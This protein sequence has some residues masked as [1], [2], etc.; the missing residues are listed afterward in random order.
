MEPPVPTGT[1]YYDGRSAAPHAATL[2]WSEAFLSIDGVDGELAI[3]PRARLIVGEPDPEG[4]VALSCKGELGRVLT[5]ALSLPVQMPVSRMQRR[6][7]LGWI[8]VGVAAVALAFVL[9]ARLP[10]VGAALVPRS[11]EN[12]LGEMV[13]SVVVGKHRVC[14]GDDG[15]RALEQLEARLAHA[16]GIAQPVRVVVIDSKTVNALT[17]PGT[18]MI[19]MRGL[20]EQVGNPDQLAGVMAHETGHIARRDPLTALFRG[21][22]ISVI[23]TMFGIN[24]GFADVSSL[25]G[26]LVGLSYSRD[27]ERL[28]DAN[29][30]AYLQA[31][32]LRSDGLAAFF[33]L[34]E[35]RSGS[36]SRAIEFLSDHPR[37]IDRENRSQGSPLGDSALTAQ[38]WAAVQAM[39]EKP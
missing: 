22:G 39:C 16:A 9:V 6:H 13:E 35:K 19:I 11:A 37:T 36:A 4:R 17:L 14:R 38:Q 28:A 8:M 33:A 32:G 18:R 10:A 26:R 3:W 34:T 25:A 12:R 20:F 21:A 30:V 29:G 5:D 1:R 2:R 7:Y 31:S 15:Q 27:M 23:S 24:L